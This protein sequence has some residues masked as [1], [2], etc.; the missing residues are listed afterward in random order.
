[1]RI[2]AL[3]VF[4]STWICPAIANVEK[5]IFIAPK[6]AVPPHNSRNIFPLHIDRLAPT[7]HTLRRILPASFPHRSLPLGSESWYLLDELKEHQ[8]HELRVCWIATVCAFVLSQESERFA[9]LFE[10]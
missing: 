4:L 10:K 3:L 9:N 1:M 8:R 6:A 7:S 2:V 5:T